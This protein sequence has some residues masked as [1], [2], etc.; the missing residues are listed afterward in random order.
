MALNILNF[1][2]LSTMLSIAT[3]LILFI[4][5]NFQNNLNGCD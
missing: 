1:Q 5:F 2:N 3:G 4:N